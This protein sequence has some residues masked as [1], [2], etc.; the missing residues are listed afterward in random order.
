MGLGVHYLTGITLTRAYHVM[1]RRGRRRA[2]PLEAAA[3]GAVTGLL[4]LLV[5]DPSW[6][7]GP[8]ALRSD[9]APRLVRIM[10]LGHAVFGAAIGF[11]TAALSGR[12]AARTLQGGA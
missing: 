10:L 2:G 7:L 11:W 12:T 8:F 1:L 5:L 4:P 3:Y 6:G 9:E